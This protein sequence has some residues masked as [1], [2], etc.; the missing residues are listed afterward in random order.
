MAVKNI[1]EEN[2]I[3]YIDHITLHKGVYRGDI[4]L[5]DDDEVLLEVDEFLE[6]EGKVHM[7]LEVKGTKSN[8]VV[9]LTEVLEVYYTYL[10]EIG[11][12]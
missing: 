2:I 6:S 12:E 5:I 3:G 10:K 9:T 1:E 8:G 11:E 7:A 4:N